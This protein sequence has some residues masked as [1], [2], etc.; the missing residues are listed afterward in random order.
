L[1]H[2]EVAQI[3]MTNLRNCWDTRTTW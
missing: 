1:E 3:S 2:R